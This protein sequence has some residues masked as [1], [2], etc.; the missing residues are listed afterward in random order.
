[1]NDFASQIVIIVVFISIL[2]G[3]ILWIKQMKKNEQKAR[4]FDL[5]VQ[6]KEIHNKINSMNP[7][8]LIEEVNRW[9][10]KK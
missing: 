6:E 1:M 9:S 7:D 10:G 5:E 3:I 8:E 4:M 2:G